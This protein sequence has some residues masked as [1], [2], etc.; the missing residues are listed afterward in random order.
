M[1]LQNIISLQ[2]PLRRNKSR[3]PIKPTWEFITEVGIALVFHDHVGFPLSSF[4]DLLYIH[5]YLD[6]YHPTPL[7][8][9][10][11]SSHSPLSGQ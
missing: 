1:I 2:T 8:G 3:D 6:S 5:G 7:R 10:L 9:H 4:T 11:L